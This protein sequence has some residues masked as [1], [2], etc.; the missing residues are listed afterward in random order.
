MLPPGLRPGRTAAAAAVRLSH[1]LSA[2]DLA[3]LN[4]H[5][6]ED[7]CPTDGQG[8]Q[9]VV[10]CC[11]GDSC[12][13]VAGLRNRIGRRAGASSR[14]RRGQPGARI[15]IVSSRGRRGLVIQSGAYR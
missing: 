7:R 13:R 9:E 6:V 15:L 5:R 4:A 12:R 10:R 3:D 8:Q 2:F 14:G 1:A 11:E